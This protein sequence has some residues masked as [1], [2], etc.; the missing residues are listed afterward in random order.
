MSFQKA[1]TTC[2]ITL[3]ISLF[4]VGQAYPQ[5][6]P[7]TPEEPTIRLRIFWF[8]DGSE[9][10]TLRQQRDAFEEQ[11]PNITVEIVQMSAG[12]INA[13]LQKAIREND[14]PD[15]ARTNVPGNFRDHLF[16]LR[17]YLQDPESWEQN[18]PPGFMASLRSDPR[19]NTLHGYPVDVTVSA[20]FI[21]RD[22]WQEAGVPIPSDYSDEVTWDE[23]VTAA[24]QV[25]AALTT[26]ERRVYALAMDRS[27]HRFWGPSLSLCA[28]YVD[29]LDPT[30]Q[31]HIDTPGFREAATMLKSW[32]D[33]GLLPREVW[34]GNS[35][36]L[37][38]ADE[39]FIDSQI[40]LYFSGNW[41]LSKFKSKIS[42]FD[43][44]PVPNPVGPCGSTGMIGGTAVIALKYTQ[45]PE[46][47]G[48]LVD[49][50]T[51]YD[52]LSTFYQD[53]LLLPGHVGMNASGRKELEYPELREEL[54]GFQQQIGL[55]MPEAFALQ[56]R[57][58]SAI[59]HESIRYGLIVML[60]DDL[61]IDDTVYIIEQCIDARYNGENTCQL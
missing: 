49:F 60:R 6:S 8:S 39:F 19:S 40:A 56:Y 26:E 35:D 25:Q 14:A 17:P 50:L 5:D 53:N 59:L 15:L 13:N 30:S 43:W 54:A 57:P 1:L 18:F 46:A 27:G 34:E 10:L 33:A 3:A 42:N 45:H 36:T 12:D 29:P 37:V 44:Q 61:S 20:P 52:N 9:E 32:H 31:P 22:L 24:S 38:P 16:D 11:N 4:L 41:Q 28:T 2:I 7:P 47:V 55:A 58:D 23:W 48:K 21:N 51:D